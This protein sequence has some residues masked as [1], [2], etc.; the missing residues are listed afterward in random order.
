MADLSGLLR[1]WAGFP[2]RVHRVVGL[3]YL[4]HWTYMLWLLL[5][6]P[7]A[8]WDSRIGA[9]RLVGLP[10]HGLLQTVIAVRS[11]P[12]LG[13]DGKQN[14]F[15]DRGTISR[16]F[17]VENAFF[18]ALT[19]YA[20]TQA[21]PMIQARTP[22]CVQLTWSVFPYALV[23]P[24]FPKTS[25]VRNRARDQTKHRSDR[26]SAGNEWFMHAAAWAT[27]VGYI[28]GKHYVGYMINYAAIVRPL[29]SQQRAYMRWILLGN[30]QRHDARLPR[31]CYS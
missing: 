11:F 31:S 1:F 22:M 7:D 23:R 15:S 3:A 29:D 5:S 6:R 4:A 24:F 30:I 14:Y 16:D 26:T 2:H 20:A 13:R 25:F 28:V 19:I 12:F 18:V 8:Y 27:K 17:V 9:V 21:S 10:C